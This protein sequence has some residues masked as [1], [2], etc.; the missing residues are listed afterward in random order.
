MESHQEIPAPEGCR[1]VVTQ[2]CHKVP[3]RY[4]KKVPEDICREVPD[5]ECHLELEKVEEP[6]CFNTPVEECNDEYKEVPFLVDDEECEDVPRLD[7][8][9]VKEEIPIQVCTSIDINRPP[10]IT[11]LGDDIDLGGDEEERRGRQGKSL[12]IDDYSEDED[13]DEDTLATLRRLLRPSDLSRLREKVFGDDK[14]KPRRARKRKKNKRR[15]KKDIVSHRGK[16]GIGAEK[17]KEGIRTILKPGELE[18]ILRTGT[19]DWNAKR[20]KRYETIEPDEEEEVES[21][22]E[23][24]FEYEYEYEEVDNGEKVLEGLV[25]KIKTFDMKNPTEEDKE[26]E[27]EAE[28]ED[29]EKKSSPNRRKQILN[30]VEQLLNM[31]SDD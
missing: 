15:P 12:D 31:K 20:I 26:E 29:E 9:E 13:G 22:S 24:E 18:E 21:E 2:K 1:S 4:T 23:Y 27:E 19:F 5:V 14:E 30:L 7:C 28:E 16:S 25:A 10:I 11:S 6:N 3:E 17:L 8:T